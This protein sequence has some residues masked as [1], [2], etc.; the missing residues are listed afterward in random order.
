MAEYQAILSYV[1][2]YILHHFTFYPQCDKPIKAA[3][4]HH[5]INTSS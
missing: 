4:R 1:S 2:K 5:P 3:I